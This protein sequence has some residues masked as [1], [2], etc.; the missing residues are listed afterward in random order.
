MKVAAIFMVLILSPLL[1]ADESARRLAQQYNYEEALTLF[2][3]EKS[4]SPSD[5]FYRGLCEHGLLLKADAQSTLKKLLFQHPDAPQR[6]QQIAILMLLDME[7]WKSKDLEEISRKMNNIR[8]RLELAKGGPETQ[9]MQREIINRLDELIKKAENKSKGGSSLNKDEC[10]DGGSSKGQAQQ[11][12]LQPGQQAVKPLQ[13][14]KVMPGSGTGQVNQARLRKL[15]EGWGKI[16]PQDRAEAMREV[17]ELT[18][19]LAPAYREAFQEY[20]RRLAN[21][22]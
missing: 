3:Q 1:I 6:Y 21:K 14:S 12:Q 11:R 4:N 15:A 17:D 19:N 18:R 16:N 22:R 7:T 13:D 2:K 10:P 9:R 5:L 8:R 20:F